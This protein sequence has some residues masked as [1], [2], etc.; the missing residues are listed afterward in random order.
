MLVDGQQIRVRLAGIDAPE[1]KQPFGTRAR[2]HLAWL[3]HEREVRIETAGRD[4]YGRTI[5]TVYAG[6][7][8]VNDEQV[9]AGMAW[10]YRKFDRSKW[11]GELEADAREFRRGLWADMEPVPPW[12][13]RRSALNKRTRMQ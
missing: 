11:L 3:V 2:E 9:R 13:W 10:Q 4:R 8:S 12:K 7:T 1:R 5:G 6:E